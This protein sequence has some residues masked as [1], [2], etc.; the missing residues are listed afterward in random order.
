MKIWAVTAESSVKP[1]TTLSQFKS[2]VSVLLWVGIDPKCNGFLAVGME[3]GLIELWSL[4]T[5]RTDNV[6]SSVV[7]L[8]ANASIHLF[9]MFPRSTLWHGSHR[10]R[11]VKS[12]GSCNLHPVALTTMLECLR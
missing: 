4:S 3:N 2:S 12:A 7:A 6:Y 9:A 11:V 5:K 10:R 8:V 1:L